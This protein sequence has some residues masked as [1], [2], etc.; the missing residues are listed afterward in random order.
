MSNKI[1][2]KDCFATTDLN[3]A[4]VL[5]SLNYTLD[6]IDKREPQKATFIFLRQDDLD[7]VIQSFWARALK[8][9]PLSVLTNL[10]LLKNR[11]YSNEI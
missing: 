10:K 2:V 4:S 9:E 3:L 1:S 11:L 5:L 7:E 8:L 6:C